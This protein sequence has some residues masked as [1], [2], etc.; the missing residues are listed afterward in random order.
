[1]N[2]ACGGDGEGMAHLMNALSSTVLVYALFTRG[3]L[4]VSKGLEYIASRA[5]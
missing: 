4:V 5:G 3:G 1:M 2:R